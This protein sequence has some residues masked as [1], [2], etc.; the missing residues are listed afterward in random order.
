MLYYVHRYD[1]IRIKVAVEAEDHVSAMKTADA[2]LDASYPI[3]GF[4]YGDIDM[5]GKCMAVE[6]ADETTGYL[7]DEAGDDEYANSRTYNA[8]FTATKE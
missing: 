4:D 8:D 1:I 2:I 3:R 5:P 7:V 6:Q